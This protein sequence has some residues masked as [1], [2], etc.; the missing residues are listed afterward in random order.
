MAHQK[1]S[2]TALASMGIVLYVLAA[3]VVGLGAYMGL[4]FA[5]ARAALWGITIPFQSPALSPLWDALASALVFVGIVLFVVSLI[6]SA[7]LVICGL[8][9]RRSATLGQRVQQLEAALER[10]HIP[11]ATAP[12]DQVALA[13]AA[14][15]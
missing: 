12:A 10:A 15:A 9:L 7:L 8:L 13:E 3:I 14:P 1:R 11:L 2:T 4:A 6:V 5:N